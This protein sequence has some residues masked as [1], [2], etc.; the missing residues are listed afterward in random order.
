MMKSISVIFT[1]SVAILLIV[2]GE[3]YSGLVLILIIFAIIIKLAAS[4]VFG[5]F[6]KTAVEIKAIVKKQKKVDIDYLSYP[7]QLAM[8]K[9]Y[10]QQAIRDRAKE[11]DSRK[12]KTKRMR[13]TRLPFGSNNPSVAHPWDAE[14]IFSVSII[15]DSD[16][17]DDYL[18]H[19]PSCNNSMP[20]EG[21]V[22]NPS[23]GLVMLCGIGGI[24]TGGHVWGES[25]SVENSINGCCTSIDDSFSSFD[26]TYNCIVSSMDEW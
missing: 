18:I 25:N 16:S 8:K 23:T 12:N 1:L 22:V 21:I 3:V 9:K 7:D 13:K 6:S 2:K 10:K 19:E 26:D 14:S 24:D 4:S 5:D 20:S 11:R 15:S 17:N